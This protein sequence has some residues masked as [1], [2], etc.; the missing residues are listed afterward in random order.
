MIRWYWD[1]CFVSKRKN[2]ECYGTKHHNPNAER[3]LK[4]QEAEREEATEHRETRKHRKHTKGTKEGGRRRDCV[5]DEL[6]KNHK[7]DLHDKNKRRKHS[8]T[9]EEELIVFFAAKY[10]RSQRTK[11]REDE[12][13]SKRVRWQRVAKK[14][15]R[16]INS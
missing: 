14:S 11:H 4:G 7:Y 12:Y 13:E 5:G 15:G 8:R 9:E 6:P 10:E 2:K 16:E 1:F 3:A